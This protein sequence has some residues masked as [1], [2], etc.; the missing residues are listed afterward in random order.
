MDAMWKASAITRGISSPVADQEVVLGDRHR[1]A[2]DVGLLEGVGADQRATDLAGDGDH[3]HRVHLGV[4]QRGDQVGG[5]GAR[6]RHAYADLAGGVR[7]AAGGV[8]GALLVA[9]QHVAQLFRVEQRVVDRQHGAARN[10]EDDLDVEFLQRPDHRLGA[11]KLLGPNM[12]RLGRRRFRGGLDRVGGDV[13]GDAVAGAGRAGLV[14]ALTVS[15][16]P[17]FTLGVSLVGKKKPP[18]AQLLHEGCALVLDSFKCRSAS[19]A[20]TRRPITTSIPGFR[21]YP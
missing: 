4:G 20:P 3:R 8:A 15:S 1:D 5:A 2:G 7:V 16:R 21:R 18:S 13:G 11:G 17:L 6:R 14:G 9:D 10:P 12:F 19:Q